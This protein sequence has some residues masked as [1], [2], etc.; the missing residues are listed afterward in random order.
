[1]DTEGAVEKYR[2]LKPKLSN[3][4][5]TYDDLPKDIRPQIPIKF[6]EIMRI[7]AKNKPED[8]EEVKKCLRH[9][10]DFYAEKQEDVDNSDLYNEFSKQ[11]AEKGPILI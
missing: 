1:M 3:L 7:S 9:L 6:D 5:K 8:V 4:E 2:Y 11:V 10:L